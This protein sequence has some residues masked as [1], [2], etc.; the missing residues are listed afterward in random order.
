MLIE[1]P[2]VIFAIRKYFKS[3]LGQ[4]F[5]IPLKKAV[6]FE[7]EKEGVPLRIQFLNFE[8]R[9]S[10]VLLEDVELGEEERISALLRP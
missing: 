6:H 2:L 10:S 5:H 4:R 3:D 7:F 8:K 1:A 9:G